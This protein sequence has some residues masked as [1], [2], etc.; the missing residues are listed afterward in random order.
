VRQVLLA[1]LPGF[2]AFRLPA[3]LNVLVVF[4]LLLLAGRW[5]SAGRRS[6]GL[7]IAVVGLTALTLAAALP[8]L[9]RW[10]VLPAE[11][12]AEPVVAGLVRELQAGDPARVP[13][14]LNFSARLVRENSGMVTGHSTF[15]GY[16][17]LYL[18]RVWE[19]VHLAAGLPPPPTINTFPDVRIFERDPFLYHSMNLA[20]GFDTRTKELRLNPAPDPRAY[21]CYGA[22]VAADWHDAIRRMVAGHD[23]HRVALVESPVPGLAGSGHG[24]AAI[25]VFAHEN[26]QLH[27]ESSAPAVLVLAEA[28]YPG[29]T[30]SVN[31]REAP[32][33]PVNGWMRGVVVP[34][35][36]AEVVW[37]YRSRWFGAGCAIGAAAAVVFLLGWRTRRRA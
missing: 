13:P 25:T 8:A 33:F 17:S 30:A 14:R 29:W 37:H 19:Y 18:G 27:T 6:R 2:A 10:Y 22:E 21:L 5:W 1:G 12:P 34:A 35:G 31:G 26:V 20:A 15:N 16:V 36:R 11:Y 3:R 32:A 24:T 9:K 4:S 28:W 23:F 7:G